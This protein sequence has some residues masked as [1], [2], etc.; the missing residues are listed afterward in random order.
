[1]IH[2]G[3]TYGPVSAEL[4]TSAVEKARKLIEDEGFTR[5]AAAKAIAPAVSVHWNTLLN[6]LRESLDPEPGKSVPALQQQV[7]QLSRALAATQAMVRDQNQ[8]STDA[9]RAGL[10]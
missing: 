10:P 2:G 3:R 8:E 7:R 5:T 4:R 1:M 6:W 9:D